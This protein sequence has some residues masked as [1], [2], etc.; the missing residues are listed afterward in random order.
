MSDVYIVILI[1]T[2]CDES[3]TYVTKDSTELIEFAWSVVDATTLEKLHQESVLVRPVNTPIT[4]YCSQLHRISWEHVRNAG[5]F[6]DA[7]VKFDSYVQEHIIQ[8]NK[9]FSLITF[10]ISK[11]RVQLPREARDKAVVLPPYLQH[12]RVFD[13]SV[14]YSK[15]QTSHPE[16]LSYTASSLSNIITALE[17]EVDASEDFIRTPSSSSSTPP[18]T[19]SA[20]AQA[21]A[22]A[23]ASNVSSTGETKTLATVNVFTKMLIQLIKKSIPIEE[24]ATVLTKP[25]DSAQDVNVFL[26]ERSKI[27]YLWNLP[28]DTTQSELESW[29]TQYGGR[30]IAFWTLKNLESV[31]TTK[32]TSIN[33]ATVSPHKAKGIAG[34][35]V[36][37]THEEATESL[38]MNGRV[39]NDRAIEVQPSSNRILDKASDL[40]TPFPPSKNRPRPG[41]WTCPSCGFS[42]FQRRTHCFRCSFPAS[43]AV[44]IQESIYSNTSTTSNSHNGM[45]TRRGN[46]NNNNN[47]HN[48]GNYGSTG[49]NSQNNNH[50]GA[51]PNYKLALNSA[52]GNTTSA[53]MGQNTNANHHSSNNGLN[54]GYNNHSNNQNHHNNN[55]NNN[56]HGNRLH[57]NNSVPFRAGDWKC[58]VCMYHNFAKNLCCLKCGASKPVLAVNNHQSNATHSVNSTAAAIAAATASGQP[59]NLSNGFMGLQQ[60]QPQHANPYG[61]SQNTNQSRQSRNN[62]LGGSVSGYNNNNNN[63]QK[64]HQYQYNNSSLRGS[65]SGTP[66]PP[67]QILPQQLMM[68]QQSVQQQQQ[69]QQY[70][71]QHQHQHQQQSSNQMANQQKY[72]NSVNNSPGLYPSYGGQQSVNAN[73]NR[74]GPGAPYSAPV[75]GNDGNQVINNQGQG[76][77]QSYNVLA[78]QMNSLSLNQ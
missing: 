54:N 44:A 29:F 57:Y 23:T 1:A 42:N 10:D 60:P 18:P 71:H 4:P 9:E 66:Q 50:N 61:H 56:N 20:S 37:A 74:N 77:N 34:F 13:L 30:P 19:S 68:M 41:D 28:I 3:T 26:S 31:D 35:A 8:E 75:M 33:A 78:N 67:N 22:T 27:L 7:I 5:S 14:E 73:F 72:S 16:A 76:I 69:Q 55:N 38:S 15:W 70:Q 46:N 49:S 12:P 62:S 11:L 24:H 48:N 65:G 39:L 59:L 32:P 47:N 6:K 36:F 52:Q 53:Y 58:D 63:G 51:Q 17:V 64:S 43:S 21:N 45:N 40:L 25:Y 2:T